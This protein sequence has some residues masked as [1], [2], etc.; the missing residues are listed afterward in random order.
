MSKIFQYA[1]LRRIIDPCLYVT[2]KQYLEYVY[3]YILI[4]ERLS[5]FRR[6]GVAS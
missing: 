6:S 4:E 3:V 1:F 2:L 5:S